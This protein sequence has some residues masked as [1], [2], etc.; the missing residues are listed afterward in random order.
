MNKNYTLRDYINLIES[1]EISNEQEL[2]EGRFKE[3]LAAITLAAAVYGYNAYETKQLMQNEPQLVSLAQL[4]L[5]AEEMGDTEKVKELDQRIKD[6][7]A[8]IKEKGRPVL[9]KHGKPVIPK[10]DQGN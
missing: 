1:L 2:E 8:F 6:T 10:Y 7:L 5:K 4:K 3:L 9:D